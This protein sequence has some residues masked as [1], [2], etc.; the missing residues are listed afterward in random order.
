MPYDR[1]A[2]PLI[3]SL[4]LVFAACHPGGDDIDPEVTAQAR[5]HAMTEGR[6]I[7]FA[8][9]S[10]TTTREDIDAVAQHLERTYP[11]S[12]ARVSV[13][14]RPDD[15]TVVAIDLMGEDLPAPDALTAELRTA[16]PL[17]ADAIIESRAVAAEQV[18]PD[19]I[20]PQQ[21]ET[22]EQTRARIIEQLRAE[23]V[24]GDITVDVRD[25]EQGRREVEVRVH[26]DDPSDA[27]STEQ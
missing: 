21:G 20:E 27:P 2:R 16:F 7:E 25:D 19:P 8:L 11:V 14:R 15:A 6:H 13:K 22:P 4:A 1:I 3:S 12:A 17:L 23:G 9:E 26:G 5:T 24:E 18:E 10:A